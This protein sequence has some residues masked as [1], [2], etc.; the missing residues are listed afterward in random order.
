MFLH[1]YKEKSE[2]K[3]VTTKWTFATLNKRRKYLLLILDFMI[4]P[5]IIGLTGCFD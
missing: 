2:E 3:E 4:C 1:S 5:S